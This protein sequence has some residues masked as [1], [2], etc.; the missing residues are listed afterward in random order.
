MIGQRAVVVCDG[1]A[2]MTEEFLFFERCCVRPGSLFDNL[3]LLTVGRLKSGEK[4]ISC[5]H[6]GLYLRLPRNSWDFPRKILRIP[7]NSCT[8]DFLGIPGIFQGKYL[9][10]LGFS[11]ENTKNSK[12]F[13]Y[14]R[15]PRNSWDFPRKILR[16]PGIFQGKYLEFQGIPSLI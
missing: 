11:K 14:T 13:L 4:C 5:R 2:D 12:E 15:L 10:F 7:R 1:I 6:T 9:E 8:R 16:I 3:G